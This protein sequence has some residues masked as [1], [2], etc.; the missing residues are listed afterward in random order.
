MR[1]FDYN[2]KACKFI[3]EYV[4]ETCEHADDCPC[5]PSC[6]SK[7]V[8]RELCLPAIHNFY[9]PMHPRAKRGMCG[10]KVAPA[11]RPL[12][13]REDLINAKCNKRP[14]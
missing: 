12:F 8:V 10:K 7:Q 14:T 2:C 13:T 6:G 4:Q 11:T 9:S 1:R 3:F 5:C